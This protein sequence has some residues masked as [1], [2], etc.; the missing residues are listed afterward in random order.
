MRAYN[1]DHD[2]H[3]LRVKLRVWP[4]PN[5]PDWVKSLDGDPVTII[6]NSTGGYITIGRFW[7]PSYR[8]A[9]RDLQSQL[10]FF[11]D[12]EPLIAEVSNSA[13]GS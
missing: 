9:W 1:S 4:G 12:A 5:A 13:C 7:A 6:C 11:Y 8:Q 2:D 10:A 3:P